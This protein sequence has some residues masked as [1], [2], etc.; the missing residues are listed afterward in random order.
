[1]KE[2][3]VIENCK[4]YEHGKCWCCNDYSLYWPEDKRIL[5]K[6]QIR[7][8]EE[9]K[10]DKK[11]KKESDASKIG[12]RSKKKGYE[13]EREVVELLNKY[14]IEAERVPL[15]GALKCDKYSCDVHIPELNKRVEVKR[16]KSGM[17]TIQ[18]WLEE[19]ANSN[20]IF[21]REDGDRE[22]W[23]VIMPYMEFIDLVQKIP[24]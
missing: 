5:C 13:G 23:L 4:S 20:Y 6:R 1:M 24:L 18:K 16:R 11:M 15:S 8:R 12:K 10:L 7:Q 22:G 17:K 3:E 9:R 14:G 2:C 21:F 19:D